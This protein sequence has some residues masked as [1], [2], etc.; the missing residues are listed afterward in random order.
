M[1]VCCRS[2]H[3]IVKPFSHSVW[4]FA[5]RTNLDEH[6]DVYKYYLVMWPWRQLRFSESSLHKLPS[7]SSLRWHT[8]D[9]HW[10]IQYIYVCTAI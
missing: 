3:R 1:S 6:L 8:L 9:R 7:G 4:S 5:G 2:H 10:Y